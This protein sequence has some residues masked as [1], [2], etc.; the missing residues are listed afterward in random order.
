MQKTKIEWCSHT[1]NPLRAVSLETGKR[2]WA[3]IKRGAGCLHCYAERINLRFGTGL[4]FTAENMKLVRFELDE[5]ELGAIH[6]AKGKTV[7]VGDMC[8]LWLAGAVARVR[9]LETAAFFNSSKFIFLTKR[10]EVMARDL[11]GLDKCPPDHC[12]FGFSASTQDEFNAGW[13]ALAPLAAAGWQVWCSLEP[14][15]GAVDVGA[16]MPVHEDGCGGCGQCPDCRNGIE[17]PLHAPGLSGLVL[18]GETGPGA[19]PIPSVDA[20]RAVRDQCEAAGV[21]FMFKRWGWWGPDNTYLDTCQ[22]CGQ[23]RCDAGCGMDRDGEEECSTCG[24]WIWIP[25]V[26]PVNSLMHDPQI[27]DNGRILDGRTHDATAWRPLPSGPEV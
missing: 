6:K 3:C 12:F 24:G 27:R 20:V 2:G 4:R 5:K 10:P 1:S 25:A 18:G 8:D 26:G 14:M 22:D 7:F 16:A 13:T 11:A 9:I 17:Y 15:L 21:P 19:R 23:T